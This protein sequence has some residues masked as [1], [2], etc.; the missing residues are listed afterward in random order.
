M[1]QIVQAWSDAYGENAGKLAW[2]AN[3]ETS[4]YDA[5]VRKGSLGLTGGGGA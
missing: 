4:L 1:S 3:G 2:R 5:Y